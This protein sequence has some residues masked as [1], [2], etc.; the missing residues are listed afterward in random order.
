MAKRRPGTEEEWET[1]SGLPDDIDCW[2]SKSYFG[3]NPEYMQGKVP[4]LIWEGESPDLVL[5]RPINW[6]IGSGWQI[7]DNG[8]RVVH[9]KDAPPKLRRFIESSIYGRLIKRL[10]ELGV[11]MKQYGSAREAATW[12]GLGFHLVR[13]EIE[14]TGAADRGILV[15]RGGKTS[16]LMPTEFLGERADAEVPAVS[17]NLMAQLKELAVKSAT[18]RAFQVAAIK[19][20]GVTESGDLV[21]DLMDSGA[22]GFYQRVRKQ[23]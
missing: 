15:D 11:D 3:Y 14:F 19:V 22:D 8:A 6:P 17:E 7:I 10:R 23:P 13:E 2:V 5:T 12:E 20:P 9:A 18:V 16:H 4:L 1:E 21:A